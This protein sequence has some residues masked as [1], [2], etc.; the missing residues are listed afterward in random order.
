[1]P[2]AL[3]HGDDLYL[4]EMKRKKSFSKRRGFG[5]GF[6]KEKSESG[7]PS[8]TDPLESLAVAVTP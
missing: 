2:D 4:A 8:H 1:M 6:A 3:P 7:R 5:P